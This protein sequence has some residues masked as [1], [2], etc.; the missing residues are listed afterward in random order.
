MNE[1]KIL[2]AWG[3]E[4]NEFRNPSTANNG[5]GYSQPYGGLTVQVGDAHLYIEVEDSGCGDFGKR[6]SIAVCAI[7]RQMKW[8]IR[9]NQM[10]EQKECEKIL[11]RWEKDKRSIA[12][13][14]KITLEN[15]EKLIGVAWDA[16]SIYADEEY[17]RKKINFVVWQKRKEEE[18]RKMWE[19]PEYKAE[20]EEL[21]R[22]F[23]ESLMR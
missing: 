10:D 5:G 9:F 3:G 16:A 7:E 22:K 21:S 11:R 6:Y 23:Q 19:S 20:M 12:G 15:V 4:A 18:A 2:N 1:I 13:V 14:M 17:W 8:F